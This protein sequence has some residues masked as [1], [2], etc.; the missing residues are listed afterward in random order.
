MLLPSL[1]K[2]ECCREKGRNILELF[3]YLVALFA[4]ILLRS[5]SLRH[6]WTNCVDLKTYLN[7]NL[8]T[9]SA[10]FKGEDIRTS[11]PVQF[12]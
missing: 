12:H 1:E 3:Y 2:S 6:C 5:N 7:S 11:S 9:L 10:C 8:E 4:Y